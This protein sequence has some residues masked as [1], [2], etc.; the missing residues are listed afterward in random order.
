VAVH[1]DQVGHCAAGTVLASLG[2]ED[3]QHD[4][5][6]AE[7]LPGS[8][9][10][11][12]DP[13][14]VRE[15]HRQRWKR[16]EDA[17]RG[18]EDEGGHPRGVLLVGHGPVSSRPRR[19]GNRWVTTATGACATIGPV[20]ISLLDRSRTRAGEPPSAAL[21]ATVER[22]RRAESL[23]LHRFWVAEHHAVPG[24]ASSSPPVLMTAVA[25]A[26]SRIRV[27]SGGIML[28]HHRPVVVAGQARM[29]AALHPGRIDLGLGRSLG[30][31]Q[32]VREALR[33]TS[34]GPE[35]FAC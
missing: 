27:G 3:A 8:A 6:E 12:V 10:D 9:H 18:A 32:P 23:G 28:P 13:L 21:P 19:P 24:V 26:T 7:A 14:P 30:F 5:V 15:R 22:A 17:V 11:V 34:Y 33:V 4:R 2:G 20:L 25:A 16:A 31:T 29:L 35:E 1:L